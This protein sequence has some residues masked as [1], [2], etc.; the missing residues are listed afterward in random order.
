MI[1][2]Q[3]HLGARDQSAAEVQ[4]RLVM[5]LEL[6][7]LDGVAHLHD[8]RELVGRAR[9]VLLAVEAV[10]DAGL[11]RH[12]HRHVRMA[13]ER[14]RVRGVRRIDGDPD[15]GAD[16]EHLPLDDERL[17]ERVEDAPG[18]PRHGR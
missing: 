10:A 3:Q 14:A 9:L 11:L 8:E 12:V 17:L 18:H 4:L 5:E 1:P 15:R 6:V 16:F 7:P 2:P 13:Q